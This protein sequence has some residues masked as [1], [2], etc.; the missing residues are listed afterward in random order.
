MPR[1]LRMAF[2]S[3]GKGESTRSRLGV[4]EE[5]TVGG[6]RRVAA[7]DVGG[8]LVDEGGPHLHNR[9]AGSGTLRDHLCRD[10]FTCANL[11]HVSG[12]ARLKLNSHRATYIVRSVTV[13][14]LVRKSGT[15]V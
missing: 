8:A 12:N 9:T 2:R 7:D 14:L 15:R 3:C 10:S 13:A 5:E 11:E 6:A 1:A 4:G